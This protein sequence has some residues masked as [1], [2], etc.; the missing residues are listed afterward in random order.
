MYA[1]FKN[2]D[3]YFSLEITSIM[4]SSE[5]NLHCFGE[6]L[7]HVFHKWMYARKIYI[8]HKKKKYPDFQKSCEKSK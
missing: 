7:A 3:T 5:L 6:M 1:I 2:K 8:R 4:L